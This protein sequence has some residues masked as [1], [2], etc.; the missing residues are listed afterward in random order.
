[1]SPD[2]I[3][4]VQSSFAALLP[5]ADEVGTLFYQRLFALDPSLRRLFKGDIAE[6]SR[7][8][9]RMIAVAV[10]GLDRLDTRTGCQSARRAACRL[11]R[12][13]C[14]LRDRRRSAVMDLGA[15]T[16]RRLQPGNS[17][18]MEHSLRGSSRNHAIRHT[19]G[20]SRVNDRLPLASPR[21]QTPTTGLRG[22]RR[23]SRP[24]VWPRGLK[25]AA[26]LSR[27]W[28]APRR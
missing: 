25:P 7:S 8:L 1:M 6:Q 5:T 13:G 9:M 14:A 22:A 21:R 16:R 15:A 20:R 18:G 19:R 2:Q 3:Q 27:R 12:G 24:A 26:D 11:R 4:L 23:L 17:R 28:R 10:N